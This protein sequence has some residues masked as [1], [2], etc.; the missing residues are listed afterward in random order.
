MSD[1]ADIHLLT[2]AYAAGAVDDVERIAFERHLRVCPSCQDEV[3]E[4]RE[5]VVRLAEAAAVVPPIGLRRAVLGQIRTSAQ[6]RPGAHATPPRPPRSARAPWFVAAACAALAVTAGGIA[7][8]QHV[9]AERAHQLATIVADATARRVTG[10]TAGGGTVAV[11]VSGD[12][13]AVLAA[14]MPPLPSNRTYQLWLVQPAGRVSSLGLG[15]AAADAAGSW[16]RLV[17]GV[18]RGDV[19]AVSVEPPGGSPQPTTTPIITLHT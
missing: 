16:S 7:W 2:G 15:P 13:A 5:T 19:I 17:T 11:V 8:D 3:R 14:A 12:R 18:A 1:T 4:L 10:R 6:A 9:A